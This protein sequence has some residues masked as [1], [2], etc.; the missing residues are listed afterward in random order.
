MP[1]QEKKIVSQPGLTEDELS[2]EQRKQ[3]LS[4]QHDKEVFN[5]DLDPKRRSGENRPSV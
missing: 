2:L 4:H 5:N 1:K 3:A